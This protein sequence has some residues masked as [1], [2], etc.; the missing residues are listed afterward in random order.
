MNGSFAS[1]APLSGGLISHLR[2]YVAVNRRVMLDAKLRELAD[3]IV[4]SAALVKVEIAQL[5]TEPVT[6]SQPG[7]QVYFVVHGRFP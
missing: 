6:E 2:P 5:I 4:V 1:S 3:Q 7:L